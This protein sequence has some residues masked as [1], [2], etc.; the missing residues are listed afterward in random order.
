MTNQKNEPV[1][2]RSKNVNY[3]MKL[4][5][6]YCT[7][8]WTVFYVFLAFINPTICKPKKRPFFGH[9]V[10]KILLCFFIWDHPVGAVTI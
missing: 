10:G 7:G 9:K 5:F 1:N 3:R 8:F 4:Y 2:A 6:V